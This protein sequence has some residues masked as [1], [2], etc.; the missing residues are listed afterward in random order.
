MQC[1]RPALHFPR[2]SPAEGGG[3]V[4]L[5]E[6]DDF[7]KTRKGTSINSTTSAEL[8]PYTAILRIP[9]EGST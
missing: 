5:S 7:A 6:A 1:P 9:G 3:V 8:S 4:N 2:P